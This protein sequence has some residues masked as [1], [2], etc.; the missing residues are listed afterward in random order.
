MNT[1][2]ERLAALRQLMAERGIDTW[3]VLS[4]DAHQSEYV[5]PYWRAPI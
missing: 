4:E 3:V 5:A 2:P 1:I